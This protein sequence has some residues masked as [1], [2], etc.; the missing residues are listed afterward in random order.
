MRQADDGDACIGV[1]H[2]DDVAAMTARAGRA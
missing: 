1:N 2:C